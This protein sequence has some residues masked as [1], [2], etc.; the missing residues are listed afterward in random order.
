MINNLRYADDTTLVTRNLDD[1]KILINT[2]KESSEKAGLTLNIKET[3]VMTQ[4]FKLEDNHIEIVHI[5]NFLRSIICDDADREKEIQR[6]LAMGRSAMT[7]LAKTMKDSDT[8]VATKIKLVYP[9]VFPVVTYGSEGGSADTEYIRNVDL[10]TA[11]KDFMDCQKN[12]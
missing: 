4:E 12:E 1:L 7:K 10:E 5:F 8:S 6:R 11:T 9:F 3:K 2:V